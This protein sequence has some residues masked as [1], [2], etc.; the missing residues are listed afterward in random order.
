MRSSNHRYGCVTDELHAYWCA[1]V[2]VLTFFFSYCTRTPSKT[3]KEIK[4]EGHLQDSGGNVRKSG[5]VSIKGN[6]SWIKN[7]KFSTLGILA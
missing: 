2:Y 6:R 1:A 7:I 5:G 4:Q 3:T